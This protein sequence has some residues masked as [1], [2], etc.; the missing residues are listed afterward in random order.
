MGQQQA[1]V[2]GNSILIPGLVALIVGGPLSLLIKKVIKAASM[3]QVY[4]SLGFPSIIVLPFTVLAEGTGLCT[5]ALLYDGSP[6]SILCALIGIAVSA[7]LIVMWGWGLF[8]RIPFRLMGVENRPLLRSQG[9]FYWLHW[10]VHARREWVYLG[11]RKAIFDKSNHK[12]SSDDSDLDTELLETISGA[13]SVRSLRNR[14]KVE[15]DVLRFSNMISEKTLIGADFFCLALSF[16]IGIVEGIEVSGSAACQGRAL[17]M[18]IL[19]LV[20][21]ALGIFAFIPLEFGFNVAQLVMTIIVSGATIITLVKSK[22]LSDM[23][24]TLDGLSLSIN[25]MGL[26]GIIIGIVRTYSQVFIASR[27]RLR[28]AALLQRAQLA[29]VQKDPSVKNLII[30]PM[31]LLPETGNARDFEMQ[32][33]QSKAAKD[34]LQDLDLVLDETLQD[35]PPPLVHEESKAI[36]F[37]D[38]YS[39][40]RAPIASQRISE[41]D[42]V[43][44]SA[45]LGELMEFE[46]L[47]DRL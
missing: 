2:L 17:A 20:Q 1:A 7:T 29:E 33:L 9:L 6:I 43:Q 31:G 45:I 24:F 46:K 16:C 14:Q 25:L 37:S 22:G 34:S 32:L 27:R 5:M 10:L 30:D 4:E 13:T 11:T 36:R 40:Y 19:A 21:G 18:I 44:I 47:N 23:D 3:P 8:V 42:R 28:L 35:E 26:I 41:G 15:A 39:A 38:P 12:W